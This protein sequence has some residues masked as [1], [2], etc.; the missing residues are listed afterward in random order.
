LEEDADQIRS[1]RSKLDPNAEA[2]QYRGFTI[3]NVSA[4]GKRSYRA[5]GANFGSIEEAA[6]FV[7]AVIRGSRR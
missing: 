4:Q 3:V 5:A 6:D 1:Y 2:S 7:D